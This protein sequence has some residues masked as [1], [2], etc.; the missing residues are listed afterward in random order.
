MKWDVFLD[1][2]ESLPIG[3]KPSQITQL[4]MFDFKQ[5]I[6]RKLAEVG[7][8][9]AFKKSILTGTRSL[10][11]KNKYISLMQELIW[12][13]TYSYKSKCRLNF[14]YSVLFLSW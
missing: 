9:H 14:L 6:N 7:E 5:M 13:D 1:E 10:L 4:S 8:G 12:Y 11:Q 3:I 2:S